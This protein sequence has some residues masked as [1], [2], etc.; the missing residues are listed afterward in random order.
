MIK[1][2]FSK[3]KNNHSNLKDP[4]VVKRGKIKNNQLHDPAYRSDWTEESFL[5]GK[6]SNEVVGKSFDFKTIKPLLVF[7]VILISF[8]LVRVAYLQVIKGQYYYNLAEGNRT[9]IQSIEANRGIIYDRNQ[10]PLLNNTANFVLYLTPID[11]PADELKRDTIIRDIS[12]ILKENKVASEEPWF[13]RIKDD[14]DSIDLKSLR[15]YN[16]L[17]IIDNLDHKTAISLLI[18]TDRTPG[19]SLKAKTKRQYSWGSNNGQINNQVKLNRPE[20]PIGSSMSHLFGYIGIINKEELEKYG[21]EYSSI[22]YIGKIGLEN[23][24]ESSLKGVKGKKHIEVDALGREKKVISEKDPKDGYNLILSIDLELQK[25]TEKILRTHLEKLGL[26]KGSV[27]ILEPDTGQ[28]L[29]LVSWPS[30]DNNVFARGIKTSEYQGFLEDKANP[31]FNRAISGEFPAGSTVKPIFAA[32]ALNEGVISENTSFLSTGGLRISRWFFP[33]W[34]SGGHGITNVRKAIA[35]SV[36]TFFYY[37]GGGYRDFKGLGLDRL[38][39][40]SKKFGLGSQTGIDIQNE[41][42]GLVPTA[43]WKR[44]NK[45]EAWY[46]GDTYHFAIGQGDL[47]ATPLQVANFTNVFANRGKLMRPYL[48]TELRSGNNETVAQKIKPEIVRQDFIDDYSLE[49]VRQG[50][51]RTVTRGSGRALSWLSVDV[52]GKTGTA[53]WSSQKENHAWFTGFAPYEDPELTFTVLVEEGGEGSAVAVP[54]VRDIL[55]WY[56]NDR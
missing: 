37:I 32:A 50:M 7:F 15:A 55:A 19:V 4:F 3:Q 42:D 26:E 2:L 43:K 31:L 9:R 18:K 35:D 10:E 25:Q 29:A 17:Y 1:N 40:Y 36:N 45:D 38:V 24:W 22:D 33:D 52:A 11:L 46:I 27:V 56:F 13:V 49:V 39:E 54:I 16:P 20:L 12:E 30:Y 14:L 53:Q 34:K 48:V 44:E 28:I 21:D 23:F 8:L 6:D 41:A 5:S 47:L 51:R